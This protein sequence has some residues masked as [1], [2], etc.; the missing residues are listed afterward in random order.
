MGSVKLYDYIASLDAFD[1]ETKLAAEILIFER[2]QA[3]EAGRIR[4]ENAAIAYA[5][6]EAGIV[7]PIE[8][9]RR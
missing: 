2:W 8:R 6:A 9:D 1:A 7:T 3:E 5:A 4:R